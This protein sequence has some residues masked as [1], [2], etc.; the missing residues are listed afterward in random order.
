MPE[1]QYDQFAIVLVTMAS[2]SEGDRSLGPWLG[3]RARGDFI[4]EGG[5]L[6]PWSGAKARGDFIVEGVPSAGGPGSRSHYY[7]VHLEA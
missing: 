4:V 7:S 6:G 5:S 1:M 2:H 3:A